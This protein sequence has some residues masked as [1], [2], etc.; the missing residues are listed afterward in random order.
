MVGHE[1]IYKSP[2][3]AFTAETKKANYVE[4]M[5]PA[6]GRNF[7]NEILGIALGIVQ[8]FNGNRDAVGEVSSVDAAISSAA[9]LALEVVSHPL[10]RR[11]RV[12]GEHKISVI[13]QHLL[14]SFPLFSSN[15]ISV[16]RYATDT[17][18]E[19]HCYYYN[20]STANAQAYH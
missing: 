20:A 2:L 19:H 11:I 9:N 13:L 8:D 18:V 10:D 17:V 1:F 6:N 16:C 4:V 7:A 14:H 3:G 12:A 5:D 15:L